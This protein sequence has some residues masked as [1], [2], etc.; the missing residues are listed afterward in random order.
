MIQ[1]EIEDGV[2][3]NGC[4]ADV[5]N[6]AID[7]FAIYLGSN[8][9]F[10]VD[11][12]VVHQK[13][14][15]IGLAFLQGIAGGDDLILLDIDHGIHLNQAGAILQ[16]HEIGGLI[17]DVQKQ[18]EGGLIA[19]LLN[20][21]FR[22]GHGG[23]FFRTGAGVVTGFLG[24]LVHQ[25]EADVAFI[26]G[27]GGDTGVHPD[28]V[29]QGD[30][31]VTVGGF[32][33]ARLAEQGIEIAVGVQT[34]VIILVD[35]KPGG[36]DAVHPAGNL[37]HVAVGALAGDGVDQYGALYIGTTE[38][39]DGSGDH[40]SNPVGGTLFINFKVHIFKN[41]G[42]VLEAEMTHQ[43]VAE[44]FRRGVVDTLCHTN[45]IDFL[46]AH[47][48]GHISG[49][50]G[51]FV[52]KPFEEIRIVQIGDAD[53]ATLI[54]DLSGGTV[55]HELA[56]Q[57]AEFTQLAVCQIVGGGVVQH[58]NLI[59][60]DLVDFGC[61]VAVFN[62]QKLG[63]S[64]GPENLSTGQIADED[65]HQHQGNDGRRDGELLEIVL[66]H[67]SWLVA[68]EGLSTTKQDQATGE[69]QAKSN[70][71]EVELHRMDVQGRQFHIEV[72]SACNGGQN[73]ADDHTADRL[74]DER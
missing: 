63:V 16:S 40:R 17:G 73:Q 34:T 18:R 12:V 44:I 64:I 68:E 57:I 6:G 39:A 32:G 38:Q 19:V 24:A 14:I 27:D 62:A 69:Y 72:N 28:I 46:G 25:N 43:V 49:D 66:E 22:R 41:E 37:R 61:E 21:T 70:D 53:G 42:G 67:F 9:D 30:V 59:P 15:V 71:E 11:E 36:I 47:V 29:I 52:I 13:V 58:G 1:T 20:S 48:D 31:V 60:V 3:V 23:I 65:H 74:V 51:G 33:T 2:T 10:A 54:I 26:A 45:H 56:D 35:K 55:D 8:I 7:G 4:A 50:T 5:H